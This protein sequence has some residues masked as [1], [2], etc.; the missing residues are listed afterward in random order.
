MKLR[1]SGMPEEAYW[2]T[3]LDA[4]LILDRLGVDARLRDVV[5]L[6]CGYGTFAIP[7]AKRPP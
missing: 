4:P 5:E 7:V 2:E 1:E 3:L 6:G